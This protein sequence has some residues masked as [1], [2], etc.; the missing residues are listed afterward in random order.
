[1]KQYFS[2]Y[3]LP[4]LAVMFI[5]CVV[6][7]PSDAYAAE[8]PD[9]GNM[10]A[11]QFQNYKPAIESIQLVREIDS[12]VYLVNPD[13]T[14]FAMTLKNPLEGAYTELVFSTSKNGTYQLMGQYPLAELADKYDAFPVYS[15]KQFAS[16]Y[17]KVCYYTYIDGKK[18]FTQFSDPF[19][20][21]VDRPAAQNLT[22]YRQTG[23]IFVEFYKPDGLS[24]SL[25]IREKGSS[26]WV[27]VSKS[28]LVKEVKSSKEGYTLTL[29]T[30]KSYEFRGRVYNTIDGKKNYSDYRHVSTFSNPSKVTNIS[31]LRYDKDNKTAI[32]FGTPN[33]SYQ[34][35]YR[36]AGSS[37]SWKKVTITLEESKEAV[38]GF[39]QSCAW[40]DAKV[41]YEYKIR[42]YVTVAGKKFYGSY[43]KIFTCTKK[44]SAFVNEINS[45]Y[46]DYF[47]RADISKPERVSYN[48]NLSIKENYNIIQDYV[49]N[50]YLRLYTS[51]MGLN[52]S[53]PFWGASV[54]YHS[55]ASEGLVGIQILG[56]MSKDAGAM[57]L[58]ILRF[59]AEDDKVANGLFCWIQSIQSFG[60]ANSDYFGFSDVKE[61]SNGFIIKMNSREVIVEFNE[62]GTIYWFNMNQSN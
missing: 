31:F 36:K 33:G 17:I 5:A 22:M 15:K 26:K 21:P 53:G 45:G 28:S 51:G 56:S 34:L 10:T 11:Q 4:V 24:R 35:A 32:L 1:M 62:Y 7:L 9:A 12:T 58:E 25:Q 2:R 30:K 40:Y 44:N 23:K 18:C 54:D 14:Y 29:D 43:S 61:T 39:N 6:F 3:I 57:T 60:H 46:A 19:P 55:R 41:G 59:F 47:N 48:H 49:S 52:D 20:A 42:P 37:G 16:L 8:R 13:Y 50:P 38:V 27:S